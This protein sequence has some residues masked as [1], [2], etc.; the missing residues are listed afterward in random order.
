MFI[1]LGIELVDG[2]MSVIIP[3]QTSIPVKKTHV[4]FISTRAAF[5]L[6]ITAD[7]HNGTCIH[8]DAGN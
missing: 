1:Y 5:A 3:S 8:N 6:F 2:S 4:L 7:L